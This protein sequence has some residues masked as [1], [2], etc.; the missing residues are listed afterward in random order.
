VGFASALRV[1][2]RPFLD[3]IVLRTVIVWAVLRSAGAV[4]T[5]ALMQRMGAVGGDA[6]AGGSFVQHLAPN[7]ISFLWIWGSVTIVLGVEL[8][9]RKE[10]AFLANLGISFSRVAAFAFAL[11]ALLDLALAAGL[12]VATGG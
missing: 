9:R 10:S 4:G 8:A 5:T 1:P 7:P 3:G 12:S 2:P 11:C 6:G